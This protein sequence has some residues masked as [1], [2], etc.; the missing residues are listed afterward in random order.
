MVCHITLC[1]YAFW[2]YIYF[3]KTK[4]Y[5]SAELTWVE[6]EP[7]SQYAAQLLATTD[8]NAKLIVEFTKRLPGFLA[9]NQHDQI[10]ILK[11]QYNVY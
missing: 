5:I 11:V 4:D 3:L 9:L 6:T 10:A 7:F 2:E 1:A 8:L